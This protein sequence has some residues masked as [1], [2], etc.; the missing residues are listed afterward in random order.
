MATK[1]AVKTAKPGSKADKLKAHKAGATKPAPKPKPAKPKTTATNGTTEPLSEYQTPKTGRTIDDLVAINGLEI[2]YVKVQSETDFLLLKATDKSQKLPKELQDTFKIPVHG[3]L[4]KAIQRLRPHVILLIE[5]LNP[6]TTKKL[7]EIPKE[8]IESF[9]VTS[10]HFKSSKK[11]ESIQI[12]A[13]LKTSRG[14]AFN[15]T[16][17]LES[18]FDEGENAYPFAKDLINCRQG[19]FSSV[20]KYLTGEERGQTNTLI[21]FPDTDEET[22]AEKEARI[23]AGG[24]EVDVTDEYDFSEEETR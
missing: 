4:K 9:N 23:L 10:V 5:Q 22:P 16:T 8:L 21:E 19:I 18:L 2:E 3:N 15:F 13:T 6:F 12:N 1:K 24:E 14:K 7:S 17:P 20:H 11:G